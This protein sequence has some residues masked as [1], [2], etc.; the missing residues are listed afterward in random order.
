[1]IL[2]YGDTRTGH[3]HVGIVSE[4]KEGLPMKVIHC[5]KGNFIATGDAIQETSPAV[6]FKAKALVASCAFIEYTES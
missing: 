4:V 2:V 3:G 6:F 5:S 1:M